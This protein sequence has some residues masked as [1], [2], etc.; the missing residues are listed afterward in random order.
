MPGQPVALARVSGCPPAIHPRESPAAAGSAAIIRQAQE[1]SR[2][3]EPTLSQI[4]AP[5]NTKKSRPCAEPVDD[6][7][8]LWKIEE[9]LRRIA[10]MTLGRAKGGARRRNPERLRRVR[11]NFLAGFSPPTLSIT[12]TPYRNHAW[13]N[14]RLGRPATPARVGAFCRRFALIKTRHSLFPR[15]T[16][17]PNIEF[18]RSHRTM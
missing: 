4:V 1:T 11:M 5:R 13:R 10:G 7:T 14:G 6:V 12:Y 15:S 3:A 2:F 18:A 17:S 8:S 16:A 9:N